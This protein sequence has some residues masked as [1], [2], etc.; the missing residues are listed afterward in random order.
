MCQ[1][2][3]QN[4]TLLTDALHALGTYS[5]TINIAHESWDDWRPSAAVIDKDLDYISSMV[6]IAAIR[7]Y[8]QHIERYM[9]CKWVLNVN[10]SAIV[11]N[12]RRILK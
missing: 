4:R 5:S 1:T 6:T 10:D 11:I 7:S 2:N 9:G 3:F 12:R 8:G